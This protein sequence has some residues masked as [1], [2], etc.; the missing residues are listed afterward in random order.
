MTPREVADYLIGDE[1]A[2]DRDA[3]KA[4]ETKLG[5]AI[6]ADLLAFLEMRNGGS[7]SPT[8]VEKEPLS[9][10][11]GKLIEHFYCAS[12]LATDW[13]LR[14]IRNYKLI[15]LRDWLDEIEGDATHVHA[16]WLVFGQ[17]WGGDQWALDLSVDGGEVVYLDHELMPIEAHNTFPNEGTTRMGVSFGQFLSGLDIAAPFEPSPPPSPQEERQRAHRRFWRRIFG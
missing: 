11:G 1:V 2:L 10:R 6:P 7:S 15:T 9:Y 14:S 16:Q 8:A 3:L 17:N 13:N 5:M 4:L 12:S